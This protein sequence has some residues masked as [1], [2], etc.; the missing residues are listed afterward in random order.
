MQNVWSQADTAHTDSNPV[1]GL[2]YHKEEP[3]SLKQTKVRY[4]Y[5]TPAQ[6]KINTMYMP[7]LSPT[8]VQFHD[9]LDALNGN[10]Y[11]G[12]GVIGHPHLALYSDATE[13]LGLRLITDRFLG[14]AKRLDNVRFYQT[15]TPYSLLSYNTSLNKD[16]P[17]R[18]RRSSASPNTFS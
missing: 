14:Y 17:R 1:R 8:G 4:F 12:I 10:Y 11:L 16:Y 3:D 13:S 15:R 6:T 7:K 2:E 18:S 5:Y 9:P